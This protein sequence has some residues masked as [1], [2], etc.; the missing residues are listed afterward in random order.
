MVVHCT[1]LGITP[2][3]DKMK[4]SQVVCSASLN[5]KL[6]PSLRD[7][8]SRYKT[9]LVAVL[10]ALHL[11]SKYGSQM[12]RASPKETTLWKTPPRPTSSTRPSHVSFSSGNLQHPIPRRERQKFLQQQLVRNSSSAASS[13]SSHSLLSKSDSNAGTKK[14]SA[15]EEEEESWAFG[16]GSHSRGNFNQKPRESIEFVV[17][18]SAGKG[19]IPNY[20][21]R[22]PN[23]YDAE[24]KKSNKD[25][26]LEESYT[27]NYA[28]TSRSPRPL[29]HHAYFSSPSSSF[30]DDAAA[31]AAGTGP[32]GV[33][34]PRSGLGMGAGMH[35]SGSSI[36]HNVARKKTALIL[37]GQGS[38]YV[39][40]TL[41]IF[42]KYRSARQVWNAAEDALI[43]GFGS[44]RRGRDYNAKYSEDL[45]KR[46]QFEEE[47]NKSAA[48]DPTRNMPGDTAI[49]R[50]RRGWLRD[51]VF[52]GDQ[53]NLT[54]AENAQPS[55]L[56]ASLS[57]L[58]ALRH[59]F[60]IDLIAD[61]IDYVAGH[62]SG[63]Y[64]AL[65]AMDLLDIRDSVR[66]LRHRGLTSS[67]F[68]YQNKVLFPDGSTRPDSIYE[69]WAFANAGR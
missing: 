42:R 58:S 38:Q 54:R 14:R 5:R 17:S 50:A 60:S 32:V 40:M 65:C 20:G 15:S 53:L 69:T 26:K 43:P 66:L 67:H 29:P 8:H 9:E 18:G 16:G 44:T 19:A 6:S 45:Q 47:L 61:H 11:G 23:F 1:R 30:N 12:Y 35:F 3:S 7:T 56:V 46:T 51:L 33:G 39:G 68:V 4:A 34:G 49:A 25:R 62:G 10:V 55:I 21:R 52:S 2:R 31:T 28:P 13:S 64:A 63:V 57:I 37:P 36:G 48:W 59:E 27:H 41:D 22:K 24:D